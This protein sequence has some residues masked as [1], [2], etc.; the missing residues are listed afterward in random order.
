MGAK[1]KYLEFTNTD[2]RY[3]KKHNKHIYRHE[4]NNC[5]DKKFETAAFVIIGV[6]RCD[7]CPLHFTE[8]TP[9]AGFALD[10][11][12]RAKDNKEICHYIEYDSEIPEVPEWCPFI[13]RE[14]DNW[15]EIEE[16]WED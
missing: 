9:S 13:I 3:C 7:E 4:C 11:F 8:R 10:Y 6:G 16:G 5:E 2:E 15:W 1:C 12:C 14:D